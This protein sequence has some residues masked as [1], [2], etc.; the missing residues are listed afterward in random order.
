MP[1]T[2]PSSL[3]ES[4]EIELD[5]L[6]G[7]AILLVIDFHSPR[8]IL[9][10]PLFTFGGRHPGWIGVDIFFVLSGFLVGGLLIKEWMLRGQVN[11]PRFLI[12]RASKI[13]PQYYF[14]LL[15]LLVRHHATVYD[16][17]GNLL[18]IQNY[19]GPFTQMW[20]LAVEE[21]A[22][23][24]LVVLVAA[25]SWLRATSRQLLICLAGLS[26]IVVMLKLVLTAYGFPTFATTHTRVDGIFYGVMLAIIYHAFPD[27]FSRLQNLRWL[28]IAVIAGALLF[29][30]NPAETILAIPVHWILADAF[31]VALLLLL[32]H[33]RAFGKRSIPYRIVARIGLYSY[34]IFLW[35]MSVYVGIYEIG[36]RL[37][38][39]S[40]LTWQ[41]TAPY[42]LGIPLGIIAT[43][44][45][46]F[47][48]LRLRDKLYPREIDS[49]VG[50]PAIIEEA[51]LT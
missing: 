19:V 40:L 7:I 34:G 38:A 5:F 47:P 1:A 14:F 25:A 16:L 18:N 9:S 20:S 15:F 35:H 24:F 43:E 13:W 23:L 50:T 51:A 32:Y 26:A 45:I 30:H 21:H 37:P 11:G 41:V 49:P 12:R 6:R 33:H 36:L 8:P 46:E 44:C 10:L 17:R 28:W 22:Y 31:G 4:R 42:L 27:V 29:F 48:A 2:L 3:S 39:W